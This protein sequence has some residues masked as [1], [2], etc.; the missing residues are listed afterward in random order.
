MLVV[1]FPGLWVAVLVALTGPAGLAGCLDDGPSAADPPDLP[2]LTE[3]GRPPMPDLAGLEWRTV[4]T[5]PAGDAWARGTDW[6]RSSVGCPRPTAPELPDV[7]VEETCYGALDGTAAIPNVGVPAHPSFDLLAVDVAEHP[8]AIAVGF[9][10]SELHQGFEGSFDAENSRSAFWELAFTGPSGCAY[11]VGAWVVASVAGTIPFGIAGLSC[12]PDVVQDTPFA[13]CRA[14]CTY[15]VP[16]AVEPGTP[17]RIVVW[18]PS[19][20]FALEQ[21]SATVGTATSHSLGDAD[22]VSTRTALT[23]GPS[24]A[25][26]GYAAADDAVPVDRTSIDL[27]SSGVD[28]FER[29]AVD[30]SGRI[31]PAEG[32]DAAWRLTRM[33]AWADP[34]AIHAVIDLASLPDADLNMSV[35]QSFGV[36]G[37]WVSVSV[38]RTESGWQGSGTGFV[39]ATGEVIGLPVTY[40]VE[41]GQP[42]RIV[43]SV[44]RSQLPEPARHEVLQSPGFTIVGSRSTDVADA[45]PVVSAER[46]GWIVDILP[47]GPPLRVPPALNYAAETRRFPDPIWDVAY[48][49]DA[50]SGDPRSMDI[51]MIEVASDDP[52][53]LRV[54]MTLVEAG[55]FE[56]PTGYDA[57]FFAV[58]IE[59]PLGTTMVGHYRSPERREGVFLCAPDTT[60][61]P[62]TPLDP[63]LGGWTDITGRILH[64]SGGS[65]LVGGASPSASIVAFVPRSCFDLRE[66]ERQLNATALGAGTYLIRRGGAAS[67][68]ATVATVDEWRADNATTLA[69]AVRPAGPAPVSNQP[70]GIDNFWDIVGVILA[71]ATVLVTIWVVYQ[72]RLMLRKYLAEIRAIHEQHPTDPARR[73]ELLVALRARLHQDLLRHRL[74]DNHFPIIM[75]RLRS[76]LTSARLTSMG[77]AFYRLPP[78]LAMRLERLLDDG[79][80]S[81]EEGAVLRPLIERT[82]MPKRARAVALACIDKW[83]QED[84]EESRS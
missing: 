17:G 58:G 4:M 33:E 83:V 40:S 42:G 78:P 8:E 28:G 66:N 36:D 70:F 48:P 73:A 34:L 20:V 12:P 72:R 35:V 39:W 1:R 41:T 80:L 23:Q 45:G 49:A 24:V 50:L 51:Q 74:T 77:E 25:D 71:V 43:V 59:H 26:G 57:M 38:A 55:S 69:Y 76:R 11:F 75:D 10:V 61:F 56:T 67:A 30:D 13:A 6:A 82:T 79:H 81:G 62:S 21:G 31:A 47:P 7:P 18:A 3:V 29:V 54:T 65:G 46:G 9:T 64:T 44:Q 14:G 15:D 63:T 22:H 84:F 2:P 37:A 52:D 16:L 27:P 53:L 68:A 32:A 5:D 60:V 19:W